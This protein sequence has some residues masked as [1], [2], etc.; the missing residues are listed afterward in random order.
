LLIF[1][2]YLTFS[3]HKNLLAQTEKISQ[4]FA[5][6]DLVLID[7]LATGDGW[8]MMTGP[9]SFLF[10][11]Q[12]AYFFNL[13]DLARIDLKRFSNVYFIIPDASQDFYN[14]LASKLVPVK[15][16]TIENEILVSVGNNLPIPQKL[17]TFGKIYLL[18][19]A[20][21]TRK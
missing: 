19:P 16:Y 6:T 5:D 21:G 3:P 1:I 10:G 11:K 9:M 18:N 20:N 7:R 15:D 13:N 2:P 4:N 8:S 12:T 14:P 17:E